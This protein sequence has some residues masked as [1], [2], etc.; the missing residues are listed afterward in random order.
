GALDVFTVP[1]Q[2]KKGRAGH[3][4]QVLAPADA[5]PAL[6]RIIF[7]ETTTI[8]V[9]RYSVNRTILEREFVDVETEDG[10]VRVKVSRMD[11]K[12]VNYAPE[13]DDCV[14]V[15]SEKN[16]AL[17]QVQTLAINAYLNLKTG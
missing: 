8:G 9:R 3:L 15:G 13:Y 7:Q 16:V 17:K 10:T 5:A 2:M 6:S 4:L 12:V 11:G 14:R 1:I